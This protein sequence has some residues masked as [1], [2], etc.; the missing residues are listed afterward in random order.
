MDFAVDDTI[1]A[2]ASAPGPGPRA[3]VR[4]SGPDTRAV[5]ARLFQP[6]DRDGWERA[7]GPRRHPGELSLPRLRVPLRADVLLWPHDRSYTGQPLAELHVVGSPPLVDAAIEALFA[8]GARPARSGEFTLR[9]FLAGRID[10]LQAEAVLGVVDSG[11]EHQLRVSLSQLAGGL[12]RRIA[13]VH[14]QLLIDLAD[15]E[16]G[17]DFVDED[18]EFV[19]RPDL[20]RRLADARDMVTGLLAQ[21]DARMHTN[22]RPRVVLAGLPNA[23]KSTLFNAL[24]GRDAALVSES[25]GT[26]RDY[27]SAPLR[28]GGRE[29]EL[30]DTAGWDDGQD[31]PMRAA[32]E[33]RDELLEHADLVLWCMAARLDAQEVAR[34]HAR[35]R[36]LADRGRPL[37]VVLTKADL[38]ASDPGEADARVSALSGSGL[39]ELRGAVAAR[40]GERDHT[41]GELL[42]STAARC[43][44]SL[45]L[46]A[47]AL[48]RGRDLA[49]A[50]AGEELISVEL[51]EGLD[52]LGRIAGRVYTDDILDRIFSRF[53]IGK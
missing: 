1:A 28:W 6:R 4:V 47:A 42:G 49:A 53:C 36:S 15:L 50:G 51:R 13:A 24:V 45:T 25:A 11:D 26:T 46:A 23:G 9:A 52:H 48:A 29:V 2:L 39:D 14:E 17:L 19:Q 30:L 20:I 5:V 37:L 10:L 43:R 3:I 38:N 12:S 22:A 8:T 7:R 21:A 31:G 16:A 27:L 41:A 32:H 35:R 18:I 40:I 34:D 44:D 33:L